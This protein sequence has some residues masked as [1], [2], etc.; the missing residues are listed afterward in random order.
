MIQ[1]DV[2]H[3]MLNHVESYSNSLNMN[4]GAKSTSSPPRASRPCRNC[5]QKH[6]SISWIAQG[7]PSPVIPWTTWKSFPFPTWE[8]PK[9]SKKYPKTS[10]NSIHF[11]DVSC[12]NPEKET[13][14]TNIEIRFPQF[15][16]R[17]FPLGSN[18]WTLKQPL[19]D[20]RITCEKVRNYSIKFTVLQQ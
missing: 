6:V 10:Q 17:Y 14:P 19:L 8:S 20:A 4:L 12:G 5:R 7:S 13:S 15:H 9:N 11:Q 3:W 2:V 1:Y 16:H 18:R